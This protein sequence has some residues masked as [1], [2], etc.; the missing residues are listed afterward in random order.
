[1]NNL[2]LSM[3]RDAEGITRRRRLSGSLFALPDF[4]YELLKCAEK[5]VLG[6]RCQFLK[7]F[8]VKLPS[9]RDLRAT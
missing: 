3:K 6:Q 4:P 9:P 1:M 5:G 7:S 2:W 8:K